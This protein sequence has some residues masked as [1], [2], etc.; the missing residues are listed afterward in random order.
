MP[1]TKV[2]KLPHKTFSA[3]QSWNGATKSNFQHEK[4]FSQIN[5]CYSLAIKLLC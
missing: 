5:Q 4:R 1:K 3:A 2:Q